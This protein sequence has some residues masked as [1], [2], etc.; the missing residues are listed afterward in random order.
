MEFYI[1]LHPCRIKQIKEMKNT[2]FLL[3][4]VL[5]VDNA[6]AQEKVNA[7]AV[8]KEVTVFTN[9]AEVTN[10]V[11]VSLP[12]GSAQLYIQNVARDIDIKN[13]QLSGPDGITVLSIS[14]GK[15]TE[16]EIIN[17]IHRKLQDS[18]DL[19]IA[20]RSLLVNK[21]QAAYGA[22]KILNNEQ[23]LSAGGK[24]D[25][26]D[27]SKLVEYYQIKAVELTSAVEALGISIAAEDKAIAR[28][29]EKI[30]AY[31]ANGGVL[32]VQMSNAQA[33]RGELTVSYMTY[34]ANWQAYYDLRAK[35]ITTPLEI[36]YK[37]KV[38]QSTG[39]DWKN[40]KL[41]LSTGNPTQNGNAP[42]LT[43]A[44]ALFY[45]PMGSS[46]VARNANLK[47]QN[48]IQSINVKIEKE[49]YLYDE[50]KVE[51]PIT[52]ISQ[53]QL[54]ATFDI[55]IP[56][57]ILSNGEP[58]SVT[59]KEYVQPATF[60]YYAV[61]KLDKDAFLLAEVTDFEKLNLV[62]GEANIIFENMFVGSSFIDPS[63]TKDTL[64][65]SMGRDKSII[66]KRERIMDAKSSQNSGSSK[67]QI[68]TYELRVRNG[69]STAIAML[70]KDQYPISTDKAIEIEL[71]DNGGAAVNKETGVMTWN[72]D[73]KPGETKTYRF[74]F[75]VKSPKDRTVNFN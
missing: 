24:V 64:N 4:A 16:S 65:L 37:A 15:A 50:L 52:T 27:L 29:L 26:A 72:I 58:H 74:T 22:L 41:T 48:S 1:P 2:L 43:P 42:L 62:P 6:T 32:V 54:S 11:S 55:D 23:L 57:D 20:K 12:K 44:Y 39:V 33:I 68:Y 63:V 66:V 51:G 18:L 10:K 30:R 21:Q 40:V 28:L 36:L 14:Q 9:G 25:L 67:R 69:K 17:P 49:D 45:E 56:Y 13:V 8:V 70:L 59:L 61:P 53:N 75:T 19:I 31:T 46:L 38:A 47:M 34:S 35:S 71:T 3:F 73:V 7:T 5:V 60:K